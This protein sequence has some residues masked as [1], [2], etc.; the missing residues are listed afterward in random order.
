LDIFGFWVERVKNE[1][2][3]PLSSASE[4]EQLKRDNLVLA[5]IMKG[6]MLVEP[7]FRPKI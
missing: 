1:Y 4:E 3:A 7:S 2:Q 6:K 5:R